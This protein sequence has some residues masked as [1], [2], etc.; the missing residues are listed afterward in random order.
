MSKQVK[1]QCLEGKSSSCN[2]SNLR[3]QVKS[4]GSSQVSILVKTSLKSN[5][6]SLMASP[7]QSL[8]LVSSHWE[9]VHMFTSQILSRQVSDQIIKSNS[10]HLSNEASNKDGCGLGGSSTDHR[11]GNFHLLLSTCQDTVPQIVASGQGTLH[12]S[13]L[14]LMCESVCVWMGE[15]E[16]K[17]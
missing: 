2:R 5:F 7:S 15:W 12:D 4:K 13:L 11:V 14:P 16:P 8:S 6:K 3:A 9:P 1:S 17:L 10:N